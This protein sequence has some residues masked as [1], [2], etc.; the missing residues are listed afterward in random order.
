MYR[1]ERIG[2][3]VLVLDGNEDEYDKVD[4]AAIRSRPR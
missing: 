3:Y 4:R 2:A 1:F